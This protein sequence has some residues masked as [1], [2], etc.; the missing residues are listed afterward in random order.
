MKCN[1]RH[2]SAAT[3]GTM[4][5]AREATEKHLSHA[6]SHPQAEDLFLAHTVAV[7]AAEEGAK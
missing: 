5:A 6:E 7:L 4:I 2:A 3:L 1:R